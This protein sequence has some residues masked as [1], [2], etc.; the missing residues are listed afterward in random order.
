[1]SDQDLIF[2]RD[3]PQIESMLGYM[4]R[5]DQLDFQQNYHIHVLG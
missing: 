3:F 1:M 2:R 5:G 4:M